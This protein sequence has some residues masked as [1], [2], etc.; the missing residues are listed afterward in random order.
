MLLS[1]FRNRALCLSGNAVDA[2]NAA[3]LKQFGISHVINATPDLPFCQER[4][5]KQLRVAILDLPSENI[6]QYFESAIKFI[7]EYKEEEK[8]ATC[9]ECLRVYLD[10]ALCSESHNVLVHCSAGISRSPTL[11]LAYMIRKRRLTLEEALRQMRCSRSIIDPNF[12]FIVQLRS[13]EKKC[14]TD[15]ETTDDK[16]HANNSD[17]HRTRSKSSSRYWGSTSAGKSDSKSRSDAVI[18]VN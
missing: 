16:R 7:G 5:C 12:S 6:L 8:E 13:W 10:D 4:K 18:A 14:Q 11:V 17:S 3:R 9:S 2:Q 15:G 1:Y